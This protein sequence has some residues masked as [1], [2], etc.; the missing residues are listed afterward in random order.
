MHEMTI[1]T[2]FYTALLNADPEAIKYT[3]AMNK[4]LIPIIVIAELWQGFE[5]GSRTEHNRY[6]LERFIA[7]PKVSILNIGYETAKIYGE[8]AFHCR[9]AGRSLSNNDIWIAALA[10]EHGGILVTY[11]KDFLVF[12]DLFGPELLQVVSTP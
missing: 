5:G 4:I 6:T 2:N 8:L 9:K 1:D 10:R 7:Q 11:D 3:E 12:K